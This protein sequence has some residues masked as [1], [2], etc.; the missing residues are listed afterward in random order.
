M[1]ASFLAFSSTLKME[2]IRS[3]VKSVDFHRTAWCYS[4]NIEL[5][6]ATALRTSD[7]A[8]FLKFLLIICSNLILCIGFEVLTAAVMKSCVF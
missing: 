5:F 8:F 6:I 2:A 1:L 3:S 4:Q 7:H